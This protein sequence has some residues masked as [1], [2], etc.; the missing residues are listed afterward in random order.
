MRMRKLGALEVSEIGF[1]ALSF[2]S[3]YGQAP[4]KAESI[5]VIRGA[6]DLGVTLFDTAEVYGPWTNETLVGEALAP[7]RNEVVI[8]TKFGFDVDPATGERRGLNSQPEHIKRT[9]DA[10]LRRLGTDHIDLL[11]QHRVDPNVPIEDVAGAVKD[12][13]AAGK[14]RHFGLSEAAADTIRRAHAVQPVAAIQNEYSLWTRDPEPEVLPL[15]G[16]L[17]IGFV[18][19]SPLGMGYLT[20]KVASTSSFGVNDFRAGSP[21]FT[22]EAMKANQAVVEAVEQLAAAKGAT[23]AQVAL[24]WLLTKG[25]SIVPIFGTRRLDRVKENLGAAE[26]SPFPM[27]TWPVSRRD[28]PGLRS[29]ANGCRPLSSSCPSANHRTRSN[30]MKTR[31]WAGAPLWSLPSASGLYGFEH[32]LRPGRDR[33]ME[34]RTL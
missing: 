14:V 16:E 18:P 9:T 15:C 25:P 8:A 32:K 17:G 21:R 20:G 19:W 27:R 29:Q 12:L 30:Q 11:Y 7:V 4:E 23:A 33:P 26:V 3:T 10:M 13:I 22:P 5:R 24:A 2:A 28:S 31:E 6:R 1:G 34:N